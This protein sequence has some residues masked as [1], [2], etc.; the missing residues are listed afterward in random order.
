MKL[1]VVRLDDQE[2]HVTF[3]QVN[4]S[5]KKGRRAPLVS[6]GTAPCYYKPYSS[7]NSC[8]SALVCVEIA[9]AK[10]VHLRTKEMIVTRFKQ[11]QKLLI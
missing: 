3:L 5:P 2:S 7:R 1:H 11:D 6:A 9:W 8:I 4:F 10:Q